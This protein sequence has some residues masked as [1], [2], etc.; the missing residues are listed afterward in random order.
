VDEMSAAIIKIVPLPGGQILGCLE[1]MQ[2]QYSLL[3]I[4]KTQLN[5]LRELSRKSEEFL[6]RLFFWKQMP[7]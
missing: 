3:Q 6:L 1:Q 4:P 7:Y 5:S 2:L